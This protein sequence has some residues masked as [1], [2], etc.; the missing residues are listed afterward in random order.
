MEF[1]KLSFNWVSPYTSKSYAVMRVPVCLLFFSLL[2]AQGSVMAIEP[3]LQVCGPSGTVTVTVYNTSSTSTLTGVE[4]QVQMPPGVVYIPGTVSPP[5]ITELSTVPANQPRFGLPDRPPGSTL[6]ITFQVQATCDVLPFLADQNNE[7]KNTYTLSWSGGGSASYTSINEYAIEQPALQYTSITNQ[8]FVAT[9]LPQTFTRTFTVTNVGSAPISTFRHHETAQSGVTIVSAAGGTIITHNASNLVLE[10]SGA[11]FGANG[12][13]DPGESVSFT[14]TY[15]V[16]SCSNVQSNFSLTWGC[17]S[18]VCATVDATGVVD[19]TGLGVPN[20]GQPIYTSGHGWFR[21]VQER[22]CYGD[23]DPSKANRVRLGFRNSGS[24]AARNIEVDLYVTWWPY[25]AYTPNRLE[26]IDTNSIVLRKGIAGPPLPRIILPG[27]VDA[28]TN[29]GCFTSA[30]VVKKL[31]LFVP[32][33]IAPGETLYVEYN[34]YT[35][36]MSSVA[37]CPSRRNNIF[38]HNVSSQVR[39]QSLCGETYSHTIQGFGR[40]L[41]QSA[42]LN[43][44]PSSVSN[45]Q[46]FS[47][48]F[49]ILED[50]SSIYTFP[51]APN[52]LSGAPSTHH[53]RFQWEITLP[54][55]VV[56][57]GGGVTWTS[58]AGHTWNAYRVTQ[59]GNVLYVDFRHANKPTLW[60]GGHFRNSSICVPLQVNCG[61]S[62]SGVYSISTRLLYNPDTTCNTDYACYGFPQ[63]TEIAV[64]CPTP[65]PQG[66]EMIAFSMERTSYGL[67]DD[68]ND[69][70]A[71]ANAPPT[72]N[73]IKR[74][75][76]MHTDTATAY[77]VGVIRGG[78]WQN[79]WAILQIDNQGQR[80]VALDA[81]IVI[82][83]A[84]GGASYS[85]TRPVL[86][87][88]YGATPHN[89][90]FAIDLRRSTLIGAGVIPPAFMWENQDTVRITL[91][92]RLDQ[93]IGNQIVST[94]ATPY[95]YATSD[96]SDPPSNLSPHA[97]RFECGIWRENLELVGWYYYATDPYVYAPTAAQPCQAVVDLR[98]Y[99]SIGPCCRY[100][101][102]NL[103]PFEYRQW[104]LPSHYDVTLPQ[105]WTVIPGTVSFVHE[106][107]QG[108]SSGLISTCVSQSTPAS[109][110]TFLGTN[111]DGSTNWRFSTLSS[112][113]GHGGTLYP[114]TGGYRGLLRFSVQ[115]SCQSRIYEIE[116]DASVNYTVYFTGRLTG[117]V[118]A[119][120]NRIVLRYSGPNLE[121]KGLPATVPAEGNVVEWRVRIKNLS[122]ALPATNT[123][124]YFRTAAGSLSVLQVIDEASG[125]AITPIGDVYPVT[126]SLAAG[127]ERYI[128]VR[129]RFSSCAL[130]TLY[131]HA[132]WSCTGYPAAASAYA[133]YNTAPRDTLR[134]IPS[135]PDLLL[136]ATLT[137]NPSNRCDV[138]TVEITLQNGGTGTAYEPSLFMLLP[139]GV[140][141]IPGSAQYL[142]PSSGT[143]QPLADPGNFFIFRVWNLTTQTSPTG[144][145]ATGPS[146]TFKIRFQITTE[147]YYTNNLSIRVFVRAKN[148]CGQ[149]QYRI[150]T[151]PV[152]TLQN[153]IVP[154]ITSI[155]GPSH[156]VERC[157]ETLTYTIS[158][159]NLGSGSTM[160]SDSVRVT[161]PAGVTY[162][163]NSTTALANFTAHNPTITS[164]GGNVT[165]QWGLQG[166]HGPGTSMQ[167]SFQ[168]VVGPSLPGGTYS[169]P[170]QTII[171]ATQTCGATTCNT[172]LS[173]G[174]TSLDLVINRPVGVWTGDV[175]T[176]W[177]EPYNWWNCRVPTCN[178]DVQIPTSPRGNRYPLIDNGIAACQDITVEGGASLTIG[179]TGQ[180][181]ICR[182]TTFQMGS[183]LIAQAG[184]QVRFVGSTDQNYT[185]KGTGTWYHV[186][187]DQAVAGQRLIL[188]D[189][190]VLDG[191]LTL[192]M[193]VIDGFSHN[194]EVFVR[195]AAA[196]AV[197]GGGLNSYISGYLRRNVNTTAIDGWY[198]LPVGDY[199]SGRGYELAQVMFEEVPTTAQIRASFHLWGALP[200][201]PT[202]TD[203]GAPFGPFPLLNHGYWIIDRTAGTATPYRLRLFSRGYTNAT[204]VSYAIVK[205]P[206][207]SGSPFT[208]EG[209]CEGNPYAQASQ[210]GRLRLSDFSEFAIAQSDRP[211]PARL[212][213][214]RA[215]PRASSIQ[216][217]FTSRL[218]G[219]ISHYEILRREEGDA[220]W[221]T[222]TTLA[223]HESD[224]KQYHWLDVNVAS[225]VRYFYQVVAVDNL[226]ERTF[227]NIAEATLSSEGEFSVQLYPNP[228]EGGA[229][230]VAS[231]AGVFIRVLS[232]EGKV[233]W[234][235]TT[236]NDPVALPGN[237]PAGTYVVEI[238]TEHIRWVKAQ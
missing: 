46:T 120:P 178:E 189:D 83:K 105:G 186:A 31:T 122:N 100:C 72:L 135:S 124:V 200:S 144:I 185:F 48:C 194:K 1:R 182:H 234:E 127:A 32:G 34:L 184:S 213:A 121:V 38:L 56:Y 70:I 162:V 230:V 225:G 111:P 92:V 86:V 202:A 106:R 73:L 65:C 160:T 203:C 116:G 222:L 6:T 88:N 137:P 52:T 205:R 110:P 49:T 199:P 36:R 169:V 134:Y 235:G 171:N 159:D 140:S 207:G 238:G 119:L 181:A 141:Y 231:E 175:S 143:W 98:Y 84:G 123:F 5:G 4:L 133:C 188:I 126:N 40:M 208:F 174:T 26:R 94:R 18:Q 218:V 79:V 20:L 142:F 8:T 7:V 108:S 11:D 180:L 85:F 217:T 2:G 54:P 166:G 13:L 147:C 96:P 149:F 76:L 168:V 198:N 138:V 227:S 12:L 215:M 74:R 195:R 60:G 67:K 164:A 68:N 219:A 41:A 190:L 59:V 125:S 19:V 87:G 22:A 81:S 104:G 161:F 216:L 192:S 28:G 146:S 221:K 152:I 93:N 212:L 37:P 61:G 115:P 187:M 58:N 16:N 109:D 45:G 91:R 177:F 233:L 27:S 155:G 220:N 226:G 232:V 57:T 210:T 35:C 42:V 78:P 151:T 129:A 51:N 24:G 9:T 132:G 128:R 224:D 101:G 90:R 29:N 75:R 47:A 44:H 179:S 55:A 165:L 229:W 172:F 191:D 71:D 197:A 89:R 23:D 236:R 204:G 139:G 97:T 113:Q 80:L 237:L 183:Q 117:S 131:V 163:P 10:F 173:T 62:P 112:F 39:Y 136:S 150:S 21:F 223:P 50:P 209:V 211:L 148:Y 99:L 30:S 102:S 196:S 118:T 145:T 170:V 17:N 130:D 114:S 14:V 95:L 3:T 193:G 176:D 157:E 167:F 15:T 158:I 107:T 201:S 153:A 53:Y 33:P 154:Y 228:S 214:L 66:V 156:T 82:R 25:T 64:N 206:T 103:F 77:Y 69:G 43:D 63:P